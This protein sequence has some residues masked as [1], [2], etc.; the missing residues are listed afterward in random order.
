M[1]YDVIPF[2]PRMTSPNIQANERLGLLR[3]IKSEMK[4]SK[5]CYR[6]STTPSPYKR[7]KYFTGNVAVKVVKYPPKRL[8]LISQQMGFLEK[9]HSKLEKF[10]SKLA[11]FHSKLM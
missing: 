7:P 5:I 1:V 6:L 10:H 3:T 2:F 8:T 11:K 9:F 4:F